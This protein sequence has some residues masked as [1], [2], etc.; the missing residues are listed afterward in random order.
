MFPF[1]AHYCVKIKET[2][3]SF[4]KKSAYERTNDFRR[5]VLAPFRQRPSAGRC[6]VVG[7]DGLGSD[8]FRKLGRVPDI[9]EYGRCY[10]DRGRSYCS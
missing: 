5:N 2:V 1:Y 3:F 4:P 10:P 8:L 7:R 6:L 9:P